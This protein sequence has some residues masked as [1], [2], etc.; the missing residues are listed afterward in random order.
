[1]ITG[2]VIALLLLGILL[3]LLEILFVPGTTIVGVGGII[4]LAIGIYL[5]YDFIGTTA[6]HLSLASS[7]AVIFLALIVLLKGQTWK[8]MALETNVEGK[9]VEQ[10]EKLVFVGDRGKTISRLNPVG[11]ALFG[12]KIFEVSTTGE[13]VDEDVNIEV[14]KLDQNRIKVKTV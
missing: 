5:A 3:L 10:L 14:V 4:L 13:F 8:R 11:K 12:E 1:M 2:V 6:G 9:G 7:V